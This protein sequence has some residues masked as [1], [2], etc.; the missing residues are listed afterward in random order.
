MAKVALFRYG[1]PF[2]LEGQ[3]SVGGG[4]LSRAVLDALRARHD[5]TVV[6]KVSPAARAEL[7]AMGVVMQPDCVDLGAFDGAVLTP[8]PF[9]LMYGDQVTDAYRRLATLPA[10]ARVAYCQWDAALPF[11]FGA[12]RS[13]RFRTTCDVR[14]HHLF[15]GKRV[16]VLAQADEHPLRDTRN[17]SCGY[18][19]APFTAVRC[20]FEL[21]QLDAPFI[22][23][24]DAPVKAVAYFGSDRPGRLRELRRWFT[25][26]W[27]PPVHVYGRWS[28]KSRAQLPTSNVTFHDPVPEGL[29]AHCLN[30][31]AMTFYMADPAYVRTDFV[32]QRFFENATAGVPTLYSDALQ[33]SIAALARSTEWMLREPAQLAVWFRRVATLP[34]AEREA[35]VHAHR[36]MVLKL[37]DVRPWSIDQALQ[38]VFA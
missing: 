35:L 25:D 31:Y 5:V 29:V 33:P 14:A 23:V 10:G 17:A 38:E 20:F 18:A 16:F 4:L 27:S 6:G 7:T 3:S 36:Q 37:G 22:Q 9:N 1:L 8:G 13:E 28:D 26:G 12:E 30:E 32:A 24:H 11:H 21:A 15:D 19:R 34:A 2:Q